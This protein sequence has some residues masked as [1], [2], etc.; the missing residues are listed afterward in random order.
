MIF[1][2][3]GT[4]FA[5]AGVDRTVRLWDARTCEPIA[6]LRGHACPVVALACAPSGDWIASVDRHGRLLLQPG[7]VT[8]LLSVALTV[9]QGRPDLEQVIPL[10]EDLT[11]RKVLAT[12]FDAQAVS[13]SMLSA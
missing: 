8:A 2:P 13:Q 10:F 12:G 1:A 3:D 9:L 7:S 4:R 11:D 5:S 6:T